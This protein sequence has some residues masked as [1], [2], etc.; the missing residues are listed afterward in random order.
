MP[1]FPIAGV[2]S[3]EVRL[4]PDE[5]VAAWR[6]DSRRLV[7]QTPE[8]L[9]VQ[10][11]V[12]ARITAVD[13][14]VAATITGRVASTSRHEHVHRIELVPDDMRL[15]AL[16]RLLAVARGEAVHYQTR[17]PR[18]LATMP[19]VVHGSAGPN[20]MTT[21]SV[22]ENGCG[23]A[24]SGPAPAAIGTELDIRLGAGSRA[25]TFR[26]VVCWTARSGSTAT[27]GVRFAQGARGSW[28]MMLSEA[29][30]SGAPPA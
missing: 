7:L 18:L 23:L 9:R 26:S 25:V 15:R 28:A 12:A 8:P 21:F 17:A 27:V 4:H 10:Q 24:W 14:G 5:L 19:A 6:T 1:P 2:F 13:R 30:R 22:S 29:K 16:E 20:Y 11:R 3:I